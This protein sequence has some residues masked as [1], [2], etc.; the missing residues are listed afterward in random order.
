MSEQLQNRFWSKVD[1]RGKDE[2]WLWTGAHTPDNYG[3]ITTG[4]RKDGSRKLVYAHRLSWEIKNNSKIPSDL[5]ACHSC[6]NPSCVNPIHIWLGTNLDNMR[7]A[8]NKG[9]TFNPMKGKFKS[10]CIRGHNLS[11][12]NVSIRANGYRRCKLCDK[13]YKLEKRTIRCPN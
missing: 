12:T 3:L 13:A 6:D 11:G 2:C 4:S 1:V 5:F 10:V 7:D 8:K 9:R